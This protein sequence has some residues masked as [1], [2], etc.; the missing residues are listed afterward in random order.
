M[1]LSA[2]EVADLHELANSEQRDAG[3]GVRLADVVYWLH[4]KFLIL[5]I[6]LSDRGAV[7]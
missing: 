1:K 3:F 7:K 5:L 2:W 4:I 6:L